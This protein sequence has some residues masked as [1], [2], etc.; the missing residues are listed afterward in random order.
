MGLAGELIWPGALSGCPSLG[1]RSIST[2][3]TKV[4]EANQRSWL[5]ECSCLCR[6]RLTY[7]LIK[8]RRVFLFLRL[9]QHML[10]GEGRGFVMMTLPV[11]FLRPGLAHRSSSL[12]RGKRGP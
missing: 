2:V 10:R 6:H 8:K 12:G 1:D 4:H 5:A 3:G 9:L 11:Y 7:D